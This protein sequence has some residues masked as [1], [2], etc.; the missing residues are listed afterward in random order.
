VKKIIYIV[1]VTI[2]AV[3]FLALIL[4]KSVL[5]PWVKGRIESAINE[6]AGQYIVRIDSI[7]I[8]ILRSGIELINISVA[9]NPDS[10]GKFDLTGEIGSISLTGLNLVDAIFKKTFDIN[11]III[12]DSHFNGIVS[13]TEE[14]EKSNVSPA[15]IRINNLLF[16]GIILEITKTETAQ[17]WSLTEGS[18]EITDL[19]IEELD[20]LTPGIIMN[21]EFAAGGF[22]A[23]SADSIYTYSARDL[24]YSASSKIFQADT[25]YI[26]PNF[27]Y[28]EFAGRHQFET[29]RF[30]ALFNKVSFNDFSAVDF[31]TSGALVS[32]FIGIEEMSLDIFR[33]K[34]KEFKHENKPLLQ[35]MIYDYPGKIH[36]DSV[37]VSG[38]NITYR[39]H[40][41]KANEYGVISFSDFHA[42]V[43]RVSNDVIYKTEEAFMEI[44]A[45]AMLM[46][47]GKANLNFKGKIFE[48]QN[49]FSLNGSLSEMDA[50]ALNPIL[51]NNASII[52]RSGRID[53]MN[54]SMTA[55]NNKATGIMKL[56]YHDLNIEVTTADGDAGLRESL[57]TF[58]ANLA[59]INKNPGRGQ[60]IREG[61]IDF[62]RDTERSIFNYWV[63]SILSGVTSSVLII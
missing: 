27:S 51:E 30:E 23:V 42:T 29:D 4:K 44:M 45:E 7:H 9:S 43:Y 11:E 32:S 41:E 33:D 8:M 57:M 39:E 58:V 48:S 59:V 37:A 18:M 5:E 16:D 2:A 25:F 49:T 52:V 13:S 1:L 15:N 28:Y 19:Q 55:N 20:S 21:I 60:E 46:G 47:R 36:I 38:G 26:K 31:L 63:K 50:M 54:F 6:S 61:A 62:E 3:I 35:D 53:G 24:S 22:V 34:R 17:S 10:K 56:L 12:I 40:A 14:P